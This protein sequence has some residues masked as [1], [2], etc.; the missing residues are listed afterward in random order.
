MATGQAP[1]RRVHKRRGIL[2]VGLATLLP[3]VGFAGSALVS[4]L[5]AY[6]T[7][8]E[9]RLQY[10]ARAVAAAV[11]AQL[12]TYITALEMLATSRLLDGPL[13]AEAFEARAREA[14]DRLGGGIVLIDAPPDFQMLA[15]TRRQPGVPLPRAVHPEGEPILAGVFATGVPGV[16]DLFTGAVTGRP[17]LAVMVP[18]DRPSQPRRVL[19]LAVASSTLRDVLA[20]QGLPAGTSAAIADG[21]LRIIAHSSDPEDRLAG[22]RAPER[23]AAAIDGRDSTLAVVPGWSGLDNVYAVERLTRAPGW[24]VGVYTRR[25]TQQA[26]AWAALR[27]LLAGGAALGLGLVVVVWASRREAVRDARREAEALRTGRAEVERLHGGL[28]AVIFLSRIV[29]RGAAL[30]VQR[31][32]R[33]GDTAAVL[34]WPSDDLARLPNLEAISDYGRVPMSVHFRTTIETGEH[35]WEWRVRRKDGTWS[36]IRTRARRLD[37]LP[38]GSAEVVGY[39][40][41]ID[42]ERDAEAR[43][44]ASARMAS[45]G[46]MAAGLAHEIR[47]PL[48]SISLAAELTQL[49]NGLGNTTAANQHL[50]EI[51]VQTKR[52]SEMIEH[53]RRFARG[54]EEGATPEPVPVAVVVEGALDLIRSALRDALIDVD[55]EFGDPP[56]VV[57]GQAVLLEQV[58]TNLLLNARDALAARPAGAPRRIRI[59]AAA[60]EDGM[61]RL[62]I[63]DTGGG[64]APAIMERLFEP[65]ATTKGPDKGTGL[66]LSICH[67]LV[68]GM[69]GTIEAHNEADGAVFTI[70]LP[71]ASSGDT[72]AGLC[73]AGHATPG[74]SIA[75]PPVDLP[76]ASL[77]G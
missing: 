45:L 54:A 69:G 4:A 6:R 32:Y 15:N 72:T 51:V 70:A 76:T 34:G 2:L 52:T 60:G 65:F 8:D 74:T 58:M 38:D 42:R 27:W 17:T 14:S 43:A 16:S 47:Q 26:S 31:L 68:K 3:L 28:P 59:A 61:V 7:I 30:D 63:A 46:E 23:I 37:V 41:N 21:G 64:I 35:Q 66:G 5:G 40:L 53:L 56:P 1:A 57:C 49:A 44:I 19:A 22:V 62:T 39:N 18:V 9:E 77:G 10:T 24:A 36:W 20:R 67:S 29:I 71:G 48:Q 55:V 50:E 11:D 75:P 73:I 25:A 13:D 12:G 33:D